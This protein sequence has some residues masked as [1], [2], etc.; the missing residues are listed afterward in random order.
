MD[1]DIKLPGYAFTSQHRDQTMTKSGAGWF[2]TDGQNLTGAYS[3]DVLRGL[4]FWAFRRH[5]DDDVVLMM[6]LMPMTR[7]RQSNDGASVR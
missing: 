7:S 2:R 3:A 1:A 4:P 6:V 5:Q